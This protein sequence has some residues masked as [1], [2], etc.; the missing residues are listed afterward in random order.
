MCLEM[1]WA[2]VV[3][4]CTA[5]VEPSYTERQSSKGSD[6]C[7]CSQSMGRSKMK[8]TMKEAD[9]QDA[10]KIK[11]AVYISVKRCEAERVA[12]DPRG[13]TGEEVRSSKNVPKEWSRPEMSSCAV[14]K[15]PGARPIFDALADVPP[16]D[17]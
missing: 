5:V 11:I 13:R 4:G 1:C 3:K 17:V 6:V 12:S 15:R 14:Q 9:D 8:Y 16:D 2:V 7:R 10:T